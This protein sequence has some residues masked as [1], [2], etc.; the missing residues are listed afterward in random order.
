[1]IVGALSSED[2]S[3]RLAGSGITIRFGYFVARVQCNLPELAAPLRTLYFDFPVV[4][5]ESPID[6]RVLIRSRPRWRH[7]LVR[8][9]EFLLDGSPAFRPF[10]RAFALAFFEWGL[11]RCIYAYAHQFL[12]F[13]AAVV[14]RNGQ[15]LVM[16]ARPGSGKSTLCAALVNR[17][18]RLLSD[19]LALVRPQDGALAPLARPI[20]LKDRSISV[21][22]DFAPESVFGPLIQNTHKGT[23][24]HMRPPTES[25]ERVDEPSRAAWILFPRYGPEEA[26]RLAPVAKARAFFR[27]A[28][29]AFNYDILGASGFHLTRD[30]VDSCGTYDFSYSSLDEAVERLGALH[31]RRST[32]I[33][34]Q[35]RGERRDHAVGGT[36]GPE[37]ADRPPRRGL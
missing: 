6:Y 3:S 25:V 20:S 21:I 5:G 32:R 16:P 11:N 34:S 31:S 33:E 26:T 8:H 14:E 7:G 36:A 30:L 10:E 18:W 9:A 12:I 1:M 17:G 37:F 15:A 23:V 24:A 27:I 28:E 2:F 4:T 29:N 22:Q 35:E 13:H 19:E